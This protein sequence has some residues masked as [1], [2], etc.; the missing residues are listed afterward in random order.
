[1][2]LQ[3]GTVELC[4]SR[5]LNPGF[6]QRKEPP[7]SAFR[8]MVILTSP[9]GE[10]RGAGKAESLSGVFSSLSETAVDS[11][12]VRSDLLQPPLVLRRSWSEKPASPLCVLAVRR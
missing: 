8:E 10:E 11:G 12:G 4:S 1:M 3:G 6:S 7:F 9:L 2:L 5:D